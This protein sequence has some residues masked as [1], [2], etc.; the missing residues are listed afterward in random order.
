MAAASC[1]IQMLTDTVETAAPTALGDARTAHR[2]EALLKQA[3]RAL[4][5]V[6]RGTKV[7]ASLRRGKR[8]L[9]GFE[10]LVH[11]GLKRKHG[12][13]EPAI[14]KLLLGLAADT[15]TTFGE[16]QARVP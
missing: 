10:A 1:R 6:E 16:L 4:G 11:S 5:S 12:A 13:I 2:L 14:G 9:N 8:A 7:K 3:E 15:T